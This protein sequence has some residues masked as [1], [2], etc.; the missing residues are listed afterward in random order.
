M[1][2]AHAC[3]AREDPSA[4][5][6]PLYKTSSASGPRLRVAVLIDGPTVPRYVATIL[7]DIAGCN[8]ASVVV[9]VVVGA[10]TAPRAGLAHDLYVRVDRAVGGDAD[11]LALVDPG[12]GLEGVPRIELSTPHRPLAWLPPEAVAEL[13]RLDLD[14]ILRFC[15]ALPRGEVLH[16]ARHGVW[17]YHFGADRDARGATPFFQQVASGAPT[18]DVLLE[19]LAAPPA[20]S[21]MLCRSTFGSHGNLFLAHYRQVAVWETTHFVLWK[22]HDLHELGWDHLRA[23]ALALASEPAPLRPPT[24]GEMV[25]FLAPRVTSAVTNRIRGDA[26]VANRWKIGLR[27]GA[28]PF[29]STPDT[30]SLEGFRWIETP[31]GHL[32]ADPFLVEQGGAQ[33]IFFEDY[34]DQTNYA[35]IRVAEVQ[36]DCTLGPPRVAL[37]LGFHLSFP[38]V[39]EHDGEMFMLPES[40]ADGTLTLYRAQRFPDAWVHEKVLFRGN[41]ADTTVWREDGRFYFFTTL[42]DRDDRGVKTMLFV[43]DSLTG[44]WRLHRENPVSSDVRHARNGGAVFRRGG[45]LF[46]PSQNGGPSYGYGLNLEEIVELSEDRYVE[47]PWCTVGPEALPFAAMGVHTY[48]T[49]GDLETIDGCARIGQPARSTA[50]FRRSR[51]P[52]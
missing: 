11:P 32:W 41:A 35:V 47:R 43:A 28:T 4:I 45:R 38:F 25:R 17:S 52:V 50:G 3:P 2:S 14:V 20:P 33:L 10:W 42:H 37:D 51:P 49:A 15:S 12:V 1:R 23:Q 26:A 27:R 39:F 7:E 18:R 40:L 24:P 48:N 22:L 13:Q 46:R 44:A 16:A 36:P 30:T 5:L 34:D 21:L 8:F 9:A 19:V 29:G 6:T 31:P